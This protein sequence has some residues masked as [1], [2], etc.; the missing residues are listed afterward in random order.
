MHRKWKHIKTV[1]SAVSEATEL[2]KAK[3][4]TAVADEIVSSV[5]NAATKTLKM[6][7]LVN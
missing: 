7:T 5:K 2:S 3:T 1:K 4:V 6:K